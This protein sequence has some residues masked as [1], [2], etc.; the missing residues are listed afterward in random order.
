MRTGTTR[1]ATRRA[2]PITVLVALAAAT[3]IALGAPSPAG[4]STASSA[5]SGSSSGAGRIGGSIDAGTTHTCAVI[6]DGTA[7]CWGDDTFAQSAIPGGVG[8]VNQISAGG[9]HSCALKTTGTVACWGAPPAYASTPSSTFLSVS[10]GNGFTCGVQSSSVPICWG[11]SPNGETSIPAGTGTVRSI[12]TGY[13]HAC[14]IKTDSTVVCWG[15]NFNGQT[16][17]PP[18][19]GTVTSI[20]AGTQHTCAIKTDG[21]VACW[22]GN[23]NGQTNVPAAL[24]PV[25]AISAGGFHVC[26][27]KADGTVA[28]WG[29]NFAG[30]TAVPASLGTVTMIAAGGQHSCAVRSDGIP[31]CWGFDGSGRA[32]PPADV[33]RLNRPTVTT[34][35]S[36]IESFENA[37]GIRPDS[38]ASCWASNPYVLGAIPTVPVTSISVSAGHTCVVTASSVAQCWGWLNET[39]LPNLGPVTTIATAGYTV[40]YSSPTCAIKID[41]TLACWGGQDPSSTTVPAGLGTVTS[42]DVTDSETCAVKTDGTPQCWGSGSTQYPVPAG[43][44]LVRRVVL[45]GAGAC[46]IHVDNTLTCWG[47]AGYPPLVVPAD[48]GAVTDAVMT[49]DQTCA[50]RTD[51]TLRCWGGAPAPAGTFGTFARATSF[52]CG[53]TT[54]WVPTCVGPPSSDRDDLFLGSGN[55]YTAPPTSLVVGNSLSYPFGAVSMADSFAVSGTFPPG[56]GLSSTGMLSGIPTDSGTFTFTVSAWMRNV[57]MV[58]KTYTVTVYF[59]ITSGLDAVDSTIGDSVCRTAANAC[60]L[61][62]A[63]QEANADPG[64]DFVRFHPSVFGSTLSVPGVLENAAAT[65]DL[66]IT[67]DLELSGPSPSSPSRIDAAGLDRVFQLVGHPT[68][69]LANLEITGGKLAPGYGNGAG[70]LVTGGTL[71]L[72]QTVIHDN[73]TA[74]WGG[75]V[76]VGGGARLDTIV[77]GS[78]PN[79][80]LYASNNQA[81]VGGGVSGDP[82]ST[83]DLTKGAVVGNSARMGG[84][85]ASSGSLALTDSY[86]NTNTASVSGGGVLANG[87]LTMLRVQM[88]A[89]TAAE[90]GGAVLTMGSADLALTQLIGNKALHGGGLASMGTTHS[91]RVSLVKDEALPGGNASEVFNA[92]NLTLTTSMVEASASTPVSAIYNAGTSWNAAASLTLVDDTVAATGRVFAM[93]NDAGATVTMT[94]SIISAKVDPAHPGTAVAAC[95]GTIGSGGYNLVSDTSCG[96]TQTGDAQGVDPALGPLTMG[97]SSQFRT[98]GTAGRSTGKPGCSGTDIRGLARPLSGGCDKGAV[99]V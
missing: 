82:A 34:S 95:A 15:N 22:G 32:T 24:G 5:S 36:Y 35:T 65:G 42:V 10:A 55:T 66:D 98:P 83:I 85:I 19:L 30:Q 63:I 8:T 58:A 74:A 87:S 53:V 43:I 91:T 11:A 90:F 61:R 84:G 71:H 76:H 41:N 89:N 46:A 92:G 62:A 13:T 54:A 29:W 14:A 73:A 9:S 77:T 26:A 3:V 27:I 47:I 96:L 6:F 1:L 49:A 78:S 64:P 18:A 50:I 33:G 7:R 56:V 37:C 4:A 72:S 80:A 70:V 44:G 21:T 79:N 38:Q 2:A 52:W 60:T 23:A 88:N 97:A 93:R 40:G 51:A 20:T 45:G 81:D 69:T 59:E 12:T 48:L 16:T 94:N 31:Q 25:V 28:C 75:A 68:V 86:V 39:P 99:E 17:V 67:G 57:R